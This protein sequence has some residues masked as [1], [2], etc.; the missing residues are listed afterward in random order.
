MKCDYCGGE[1]KEGEETFNV[2]GDFV[3]CRDC[4]ENS[5]GWWMCG[6]CGTL[7][8]SADSSYTVQVRNGDSEYYCDN[9]YQQSNVVEC[10]NCGDYFDSN[11]TGTY[12]DSFYICGSCED[13]GVGVCCG[14]GRLGEVDED[15]Y[16]DDCG[17]E[18]DIHDYSYVPCL[19]FHKTD[20]E[21]AG[22]PIYLGFE[23]EVDGS[24]GVNSA[25]TAMEVT[26]EDVCW[27]KSDGSLDYGFEMVSHPMTLAYH[28]GA[29]WDWRV[30]TI[31]AGGWRS[32]DC[33]NCGFHVHVNR[34]AL[35][36]VT[37]EALSDWIQ[38]KPQYT[39][40]RKV[41]Q[42][43]STY[44]YYY[45]A[46]ARAHSTTVEQA[47]RGFLHGD[48][49]YGA[50]NFSNPDTIEFRVFKG[51]LKYTTILSYLETVDALVRH[52]RDLQ[53]GNALGMASYDGF[54]EFIKNNPD[55]Y[56]E[57]IEYAKRK[58]LIIEPEG[59]QLCLPNVD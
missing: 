41:A 48:Y 7:L 59:E 54:L 51:T 58:G 31:L 40:M 36:D 27:C 3:V 30:A 50:M 11:L 6:H 43:K 15:G 12:E 49:R 55:M 39:F 28:K 8:S 53:E 34:T 17:S 37:W 33:G 18:G 1:I 4:W 14:C 2:L 32:F 56:A 5:N 23:L 47:R 35:E 57:L 42:R 44:A 9:C 24:G 29:G 46:F 10:D 21:P 13:N 22:K 20:H 52:F 45:E 19:E 38:D 25:D 16:C 26:E